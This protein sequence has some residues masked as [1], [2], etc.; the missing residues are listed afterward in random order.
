MSSSSSPGDWTAKGSAW[1]FYA[2][3]YDPAWKALVD[4]KPAKVYR[5]NVGF[6]AVHVP[7]GAGTVTFYFD[8]GWRDVH[9]LAFVIAAGLLTLALTGLLFTAPWLVTIAEEP[10]A[11]PAGESLRI[12]LIW[13]AL[14]WLAR[15][16]PLSS[17]L[18][19]SPHCRLLLSGWRA[20]LCR[21]SIIKTHC[22]KA[23]SIRALH[24]CVFTDLAYASG[25]CPY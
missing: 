5:A 16:R 9:C 6:K 25:W 23:H 7:K 24:D 4:E 19:T 14:A 20:S 3:A 2:D 15:S 13:A 21:L 12:L 8:G 18:P 11:P 22:D 10:A 17:C 1:L